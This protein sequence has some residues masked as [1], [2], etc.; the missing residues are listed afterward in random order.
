MEG[1]NQRCSEK[2]ILPVSVPATV[3]SY[4][5]SVEQPNIDTEF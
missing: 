5:A 1:S 4:E 3:T 2:T